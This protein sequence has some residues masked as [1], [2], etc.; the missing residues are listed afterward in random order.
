MEIFIASI[1]ANYESDKFYFVTAT[2]SLSLNIASSLAATR[3]SWI[4]L[5]VVWCASPLATVPS[6]PPLLIATNYRHAGPTC[7]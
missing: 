2:L 3:L 4:A 5:R 7:I 6:A 1:F